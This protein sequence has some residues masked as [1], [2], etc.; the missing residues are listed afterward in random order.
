MSEVMNCNCAGKNQC[1]DNKTE[2][3][4][5][6]EIKEANIKFNEKV[7]E[8]DNYQQ[9]IHELR[10]KLKACIATQAELSEA[11]ELMEDNYNKEKVLREKKINNLTE[12]FAME[13]KGYEEQILAMELELT[14]IQKSNAELRETLTVTE[15]LVK[16]STTNDPTKDQEMLNLKEKIISLNAELEQ[17]FISGRELLV[18]QQHMEETINTLQKNYNEVQDILEAKKADL[19]SLTEVL[20]TTR[21]ELIICRSELE[22]LRTVPASVSVKGNSLFAE[23]E[24]SRR[25][26]LHD[27]TIL[28]KKYI[29]MKQT[30]GAKEDEIKV[31]KAERATLLR[32][33]EYENEQTVDH[34]AQLMNT[35]KMRISELENKL[36]ITEKQLKSM[37]HNNV[38]TSN[39]FS[40]LQSLLTTKKKEVEELLNKLEER[41][42][43]KI[44][45]EEIKYETEK[46]LR[47]WRYKAM[48]YKAQLLATKTETKC[49][50]P[51]EIE[52]DCSTAD[53]DLSSNMDLTVCQSTEI[54]TPSL[55]AI[56]LKKTADELVQVLQGSGHE[57]NMEDHKNI[58]GGFDDSKDL[59]QNLIFGQSSTDF[60]YQSNKENITGPSG[61]NDSNL[62][63]A[64]PTSGTKNLSPKNRDKTK[65][66]LR[67]TSD[68]VDPQTSKLVRQ[69]AEKKSYPVV[70]I[71][72]QLDQ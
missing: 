34:G 16:A 3:E 29:H 17:Q 21:D 41:S 50:A 12:K 67:F 55:P 52:L 11:N 18:K 44:L 48:S 9:E 30:Y 28:R 57:Q 24:D 47:K 37:D 42:T 69:K 32:K 5:L 19:A 61:A 71:S 38:P 2:E 72:N 25:D 33:W 49:E 58:I 14:C 70:F 36:K 68:T 1:K 59:P 27:M 39:S 51:K 64:L 66:T 63:S 60:K 13:K 46:E 4:L 56:P 26:L 35:Y 22:S 10:H 43:Q 6:D 53:A 40:Y 62:K 31:L 8:N 23:V 15:K 7:I 54:M 20:R 65:K 45:D